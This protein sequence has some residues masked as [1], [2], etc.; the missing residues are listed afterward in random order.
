MKRVMFDDRTD[1]VRVGECSLS[2]IYVLKEYNGNLFKLHQ[3]N[4]LSDPFIWCSLSDSHYNRNGEHYTL[5]E[6]LMSAKLYGEVYEFEFI[7]DF[8]QWLTKE[9]V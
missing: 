6:A 2:R 5:E 1:E 3:G 8:A 9:A 7:R 4:E